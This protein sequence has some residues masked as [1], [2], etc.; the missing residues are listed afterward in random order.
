MRNILLGGVDSTSVPSHYILVNNDDKNQNHRKNVLIHENN[1]NN[2]NEI[3]HDNSNNIIQDNNSSIDLKIDTHIR[4]L[5]I[6]I[7]PNIQVE[8]DCSPGIARQLSQNNS[9]NSLHMI[10]RDNSLNSMIKHESN[11][12][13]DDNVSEKVNFFRENFSFG[14]PLPIT[15]NF[16]SNINKYR[17]YVHGEHIRDTFSVSFKMPDRSYTRFLSSHIQRYSNGLVF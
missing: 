9:L 3:I 6:N 8:H 17:S 16:W 2:N 11:H 4:N 1:D 7:P 5:S 14:H 12:S 15:V 13:I 10:S